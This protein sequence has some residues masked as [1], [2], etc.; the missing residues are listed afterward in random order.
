MACATQRQIELF[1]RRDDLP[2][3][4]V[5]LRFEGCQ[6]FPFRCRF[7]RLPETNRLMLRLAFPPAGQRLIFD[8]IDLRILRGDQTTL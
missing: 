3:N 1:K 6:A 4:L 8:K 5:E 2:P 7:W